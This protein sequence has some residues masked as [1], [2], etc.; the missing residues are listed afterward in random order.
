MAADA[1][2]IAAGVPHELDGRRVLVT[3]GSRGIGAAVVARLAAAGAQVVTTARSARPGT[4]AAQFIA[5]DLTTREGV[6]AV[7]DGAL[8]Q[9]GG[10]DII[11]NNAGAAKAYPAGSLP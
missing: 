6:E 10:I 11:V 7:A 9:L 1:H 4:P 2:D 5:G 3:G 8:K